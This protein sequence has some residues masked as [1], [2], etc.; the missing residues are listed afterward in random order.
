MKESGIRITKPGNP[1]GENEVADWTG[2]KDMKYLEQSRS[3][4]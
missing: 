1:P 2:K 3:R 4:K